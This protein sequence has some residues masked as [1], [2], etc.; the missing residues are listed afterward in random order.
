MPEFRQRRSLP[1]RGFWTFDFHNLEKRFC[2]KTA[3]HGHKIFQITLDKNTFLQQQ[4]SRGGEFSEMHD[5]VPD[6]GFRPR[7]DFEIV[8]LVG[9]QI[10]EVHLEE[11]RER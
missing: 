2:T 11:E 9:R 8:D 6:L 5:F 10:I 3:R 1:S 7:L 4:S